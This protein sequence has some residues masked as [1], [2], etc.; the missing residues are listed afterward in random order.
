MFTYQAFLDWIIEHEPQRWNSFRAN[1]LQRRNS[2]QRCK[3]QRYEPS[4]L[5]I[6][7]EPAEEISFYFCGIETYPT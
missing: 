4:E 7:K 2:F 5:K 3:L 6:I 1:Y